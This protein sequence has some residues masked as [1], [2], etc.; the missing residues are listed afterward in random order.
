MD[1][2]SAILKYNAEQEALLSAPGQGGD[3]GGG[4]VAGKASSAK[5]EVGAALAYRTSL[6][7]P[8]LRA[9]LKGAEG[10]RDRAEREMDDALTRLL[11][12]PRAIRR[13]EDGSA[14][15]ST[16][17]GGTVNSAVTGAATDRGLPP[18]GRRGGGEGEDS[19]GRR[20]A[21]RQCLTAHLNPRLFPSS[22]SSSLESDGQPQVLP[23]TIHMPLPDPSEESPPFFCVLLQVSFFLHLHQTTSPSTPM[24]TAAGLVPSAVLPAALDDPAHRQRSAAPFVAT[25]TQEQDSSGGMQGDQDR[26]PCQRRL[27]VFTD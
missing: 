18:S 17:S 23:V 6:T 26:A 20:S 11:R 2:A 7:V 27:L 16:A 5:D 12:K 15:S 1:D 24:C 3:T 22:L 21:L 8:E 19:S 10:R 9:L 25:I 13:Q 14:G 4:G